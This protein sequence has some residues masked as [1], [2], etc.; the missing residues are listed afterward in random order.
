MGV[1]A[2]CAADLG[3]EFVGPKVALVLGIHHGVVM[4][5]TAIFKPVSLRYGRLLICLEQG[6]KGL[7]GPRRRQ[8]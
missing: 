6:Q 1:M 8:L 2:G 5:N 7:R 3:K 4:A